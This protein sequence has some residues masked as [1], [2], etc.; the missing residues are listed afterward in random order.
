MYRKIFFLLAVGLFIFAS[1]SQKTKDQEPAEVVVNDKPTL[2]VTLIDST[3]LVIREQPGNTVLIFF[4]T[5]C[6][7]CQREAQ[8]IREKIDLFNDYTIY[9]ISNQPSVLIKEFSEKYKLSDIANVK[10]GYTAI[11]QIVRNFGAIPTP[12]IYIY[13]AEGK[14]L[15]KFAGETPIEEIVK[16]L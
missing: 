7:H 14:L 1:C 2:P 6:E 11:S 8:A 12:S 15:N 5:D 16:S 13:S 10:F 4:L 9:F 3:K